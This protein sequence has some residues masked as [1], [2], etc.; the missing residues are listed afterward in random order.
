M[1][2]FATT[3]KGMEEVLA[4]ELASV[5]VSLEE[6]FPELKTAKVGAPTRAGVPFSGPVAAAYA[7]CLWSRIANRILLPVH[8]FP[9]PN[10]E[11]LYGGAKS[12]RWSDHLDPRN[13]LA[14][15][16]QC[17]HSAITHSQ[18]GAQKTKDA[19]CDQMRSIHGE[20]PSVDLVNPDLRINVYLRNDEASLAIDLSGASLHERGYRT[21]Q[22]EAP[23]KE[24]LAAA[25][26]L[27]AEYPEIVAKGGALVDP[28]CGA[29]TIPLEAA[30]IATRTAPGLFRRR[31][32]FSAWKKHD[33]KLWDSLL[34]H[35]K[36]V[37]VLDPK[38]LPPIIGFDTDPLAIRTALANLETAGL[39]GV[40]HF[41]KRELDG[42]EPPAGAETGLFI[43]NPPY[44]ERLG[45]ESE[46]V[47]LYRRIGDTMKK[48]F[49]GWR[50]GI[51]T[52]SSVLAK[53]VGLKASR[54]HVLFNGAI[55]CRLLTYE[56]YV[57]TRKPVDSPT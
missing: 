19:I 54:R 50:G 47:P 48:K 3:A 56:L 8:Q 4:R 30:L 28:M 26:L 23:M 43:V 45:E 55:E 13:T 29:G 17:T 34:A 31:W 15:D 7:A 6:T 24:N 20:R 36:S 57:G 5:F 33:P 35:A 12:V 40:A 18:F 25:L 42:A 27:L 52:G 16:F 1:D 49:K 32:G 14:V 41:E 21:E 11:K 46:L 10:P 53:E 9:A 22:R 37:R 44:G 39:R 51:F 2:F 38:K